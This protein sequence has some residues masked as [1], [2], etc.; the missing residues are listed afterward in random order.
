MANRRGRGEGSFTKLKSGAWR[1]QLMDG[2][3]PEGKRYVI[4][5]T[6]PTKGEVQ[7]KIREYIAAKEAGEIVLRAKGKGFSYWADLWYADHKDQ[8]QESTYSGYKFTLKLVKD[9]FKD[10]PIEAIKPLD[11][12]RFL[13]QL[14]ED[15]SS[16][17][18]ANKCR[19]MLMQIF[20]FAEAN[21]AV[22]RNPARLAKAIRE[23]EDTKKHKDAF[24]E[25]ETEHLLRE[26]PEDKLG[27]SIRLLLGSGLRVQ[28][29]LALKQEDLAEDGSVIFV[30]RAIKTVDGK[31][32][33][34]STKSR[35]GVRNVPIPESYRASVRYLREHGGKALIWCSGRG[36]L[37]YGTG[38]FRKWYYR[39]LREVGGVRLLPPHCCRHTYVSRLEAKGVPMEQIARLVGHTK[40]T[41][42]DIYLHVQADALQNAVAVLNGKEGSAE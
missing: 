17:S 33:L 16:G 12:N 20:D 30:R 22:R 37:V 41:T 39:A 11:I 23:R 28:E 19:A 40:I 3:T 26:L 2:Y 13:N 9:H 1:G 15:G 29:L 6:A 38:T 25:E 5:F 42:T 21:E 4:S 34:G 24:S 8:V 10:S 14:I 32:E 35:A 36:N 27:H 31:A 7:R 18:K